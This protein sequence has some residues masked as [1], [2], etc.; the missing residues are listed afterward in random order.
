MSTLVTVN[1]RPVS[2]RQALNWSALF[3]VP[4]VLGFTVEQVALAR[5]A[6]TRGFEATPEEVRELFN[7]LRYMKR[8]ESGD[9]LRQWMSDH[10]L[11][12]GN[13]QSG[14]E[15]AVKR[16]KLRD[17]ISADEI[18][19]YYAENRP[20]YERVEIY[21]ICVPAEDTAREIYAQIV[22]EDESF[23]L[24]AIEQ[25]SD[26]ETAKRGGYVG[27]VSRTD[28]PGEVEAAVFGAQ[29]GDVVGPVKT[30]LGWQ[31]LL[32]HAA[33]TIPLE[34]VSG[35]IRETLF[36]EMIDRAIKRAK[37]VYDYAAE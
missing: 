3:D 15:L 23:S 4:S 20:H 30:E 16:R 37:I 19:G 34:A 25:S 7:E 5:E 21:R 8:L 31:V 32:V 6:E 11:D 22:D 9:A 2:V 10:H 33:R 14:C 28:V 18:A 24:L 36:R 35:E 26:A 13:I 17:S 1:E 12:I 27:E 29:P